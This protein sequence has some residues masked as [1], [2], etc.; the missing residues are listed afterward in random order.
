MEG[1]SVNANGA[2]FNI[3]KYTAKSRPEQPNYVHGEKQIAARAL[4]GLRGL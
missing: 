4:H 3:R 1:S 2:P